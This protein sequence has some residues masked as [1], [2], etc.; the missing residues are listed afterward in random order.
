MIHLIVTVNFQLDVFGIAF[1]SWAI[2]DVRKRSDPCGAVLCVC[3]PGTEWDEAAPRCRS[4]VSSVF[5]FFW[6][7]L[8]VREAML[9]LD[10]CLQD[11][12]REEELADQEQLPHKQEH[13][14]IM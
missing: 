7:M 1:Y 11:A 3:L 2:R 6:L 10:L 12:Q 8:L 13:R 9:I 4:Q 14:K 5:Y